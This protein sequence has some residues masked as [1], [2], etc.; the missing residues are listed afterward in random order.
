[1]PRHVLFV[2]T[3]LAPWV[4]GGAGTL[5]ARVRQALLGEGHTVTTLLV[6]P[7]VDGLP[8]DVITV[9]TAPDFEG[10]SS[11]AADA[12]AEMVAT[13][14]ID[15]IE[16]Q[17]FDGLG[18]EALCRRSELG[19]DSLPVQVRFHGTADLMFEAIGVEPVEIAVARAMERGA[20]AMADAVVVPSPAVGSLVAERYGVEADRIVVGTPPVPEVPQQWQEPAASPLIV[21]VGRLSEVKGTHDLV[22][23]AVPLLRSHPAARLRIIGPD[24]WS[25]TAQRPMAEW[26]ATM[27]PVDVAGRIEI[28][29]PRYGAALD[30]AVA[31][32]WFA[33][34]PSR[35]DSFSLAAHEARLRGLP[36]V[37][38]DIAAFR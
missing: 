34:H 15:L 28:T 31:G 12:I 24:G 20:M 35:F 13:R 1:M 26:L 22:V 5:L 36:V 7:A 17:D 4:P 21:S 32:A 14:E 27:I 11:V 37:V 9:A 6:A 29:G 2:T 38:P 16:I 30:D 10:H 8:D 18:H 3:E 19:I 25:A 23:A 33:V